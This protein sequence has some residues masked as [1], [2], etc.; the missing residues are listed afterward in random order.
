M[1]KSDLSQTDSIECNDLS[2]HDFK[3]EIISKVAK[4]K[5]EKILNLCLESDLEAQNQV[6]QLNN[7]TLSS[8]S[9]IKKFK[10]DSEPQRN[11]RGEIELK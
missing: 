10:E 3:R 8:Y 4:S 5:L 2:N 7:K 1:N 6:K 11:I 9:N